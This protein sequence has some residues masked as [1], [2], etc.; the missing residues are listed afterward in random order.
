MAPESS[1]RVDRRRTAVRPHI[2]AL[3]WV[4]EAGLYITSATGYK[5]KGEGDLRQSVE[6]LHEREKIRDLSRRIVFQESVMPPATFRDAA[7]LK[8]AHLEGPVT[9]QRR[10]LE[11]LRAQSGGSVLLAKTREVSGRRVARTTPLLEVCPSRARTSWGQACSSQGRETIA[12]PRIVNP[13]RNGVQLLVAH[14]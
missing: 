12:L 5:M 14:I 10:G 3:G 4:I 6:P 1:H 7:V 11:N 2:R 8:G 13:G 9:C